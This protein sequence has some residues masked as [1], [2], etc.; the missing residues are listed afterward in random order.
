MSNIDTNVDDYTIDELLAVIDLDEDSATSS[1]ITTETNNYIQKYTNSGDQQMT[2][3][4]QDMQTK[5]LQYVN[6]L[7]N[8]EDTGDYNPNGD[9][10]QNWYENEALPQDDSTQSDKITSRKQEIDVYDNQHN[11]MTRN[12]LGVN[13]TID[14]KIAQDVLNPNL[15]NVTNRII[16]L[17]SQYRQ[18]D[19]NSSSTSTD[20]TLNLSETLKNVLSLRLYSL[21]IPFSW[22][23]IDTMFG[24]TCFW[25]T[26]YDTFGTSTTYL[27]E[28]ASGN[29]SSDEFVTA[30]NN[31]F[32]ATFYDP[33]GNPYTP[34]T[35]A[36]TPLP[37]SGAYPVSYDTKTGKITINLEG[38]TDPQGYQIVGAPNGTTPTDV[39]PY[40][41]FFDITRR[42]QCKENCASPGL[43]IDRSLGW[44][45]GYTTPIVQ[46]S[47]TGNTA[48]AILNLF[49]PKYFLLIIDDFN[50]NHINNGVVSISEMT[51]K[52]SLPNYYRP[53]L[54][55]TCVPGS[56]GQKKIFKLL[57]SAPRT[58]TQAQMYTINEI[59]KNRENDTSYRGKPPSSSET[60]A[61]IPLKVTG[62][63]I[64]D[65]YVDFS[66]T[67]QDNKRTYFGPVDIDR[68]HVKLMDDKGYVVNLN[69]S[70]WCVTL[71]SEN[72]YQY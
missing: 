58:L 68:F 41:T 44:I 50:Q 29:Y 67:L 66:G 13:N 18:Q 35:F 19:T 51:N 70:D 23:V 17:D 43:C 14:T 1:T 4:F 40:I 48:S 21:Q 3:F 62:L 30:L 61:V 33:L 65:V 55:Y 69:G 2:T 10:T 7:E 52:L 36:I 57:P 24:N 45:M 54:P 53:D 39:S 46:I 38:F 8:G 37:T 31:A 5:L 49:G 63:S 26:N 59:N 12:Q 25:V 20:Y 9:Q 71:I 60:L 42:L 47:N 34:G 32:F 22:Y 16:I 56:S 11:P 6:N 28:I 27:I 64:G 72:L 15:E